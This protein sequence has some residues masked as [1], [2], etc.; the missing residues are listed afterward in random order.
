MYIERTKNPELWTI[1][2][3]AGYNGFRLQALAFYAQNID[4]NWDGGSRDYWTFVRLT[5]KAQVQ[6]PE[7]GNINQ[8][9]GCKITE[10][11]VDMCLVK[12]SIG[13]HENC[14]IYFNPEA[15]TKYLPPSS[16]CPGPVKLVVH[17]TAGFKSSYNGVKN[18]RYHEYK[19]AG[20]KMSGLRWEMTKDQAYALGYL[21]KAGAI[22][23]A[24][25]NLRE[26]EWTQ[27]Y[28]KMVEKYDIKEG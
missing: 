16:E 1:A 4:S 22:T 17:F 6:L 24:G 27:D 7:C 10:L 28:K 13:Y 21:N 9:A 26:P 14:V 15:I 23:P 25:R 18:L 20:G 3:N 2:R 8:R 12:H 5:D 11:P 19:Q